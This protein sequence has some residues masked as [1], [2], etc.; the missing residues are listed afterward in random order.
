MKENKLSEILNRI[1][2][3]LFLFCF[4]T[5]FLSIIFTGYED[6]KH[7]Y[8]TNERLLI[9]FAAF[10]LLI[11]F[12]AVYILIQKYN[13]RPNLQSTPKFT[14]KQAVI[15]FFCAV[16]VLFLLQL[17]SGYLL[18]MKPVTDMRYIERYAGSFA[19]T[20]NY[21]LI[22]KDCA[23][24]S[25]YLIRYPNNFALVFL[26]SAIYRICYLIF[27]YVPSLVPVILNALAINI[28]VLLT[29][30]TARKLFG[31][32]KALFVLALCFLF[33]PFYTY[34]PYYYT[35]SLS[36]P[37]CIGAIYIFICA[38]KSD[39]KYKKYIMLAVC[40][41]VIFIGYKLKGS[42]LILLA[43]A[44]IYTVLKFS[45]K[46]TLCIALAL[47]AGFG[48]VSAAFTAGFNRSGIV[49]KEQSDRYEYP[50]THWV[51]MGLKGLGHYN[52]KDSNYTSSFETKKEK[53]EANIQE[54]K[55]RI[56]DFGPDGLYDHLI[57]KAVWTWE[58]G[59]YY[60]SHHISD[61]KRENALHSFVL[62]DGENYLS[63]F[64]YSN[65]FQLLLLFLILLSV[66]RGCIKP[67]IDIMTLFKGIIFAVLI[68]LLIWETRSRYL[69][70]FT[71]LFIVVAA[72][73]LDFLLNG[74]KSLLKNSK[75]KNRHLKA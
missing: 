60:I 72:D 23:K 70:N 28:T 25:V 20:G 71:P 24:G 43:A 2:H 45:I 49:T 8:S 27:G 65:G 75:Y 38:V 6:E 69:Y 66:I 48:C 64:V 14:D 47:I 52:L 73:G 29:V 4:G 36:A 57:N 41:T 5:V 59:T 67:K 22:Q 13:N 46:Q 34:V 37:F 58:D 54:I 63:F 1:F 32:R 74:I 62:S 19:A 15:F 16:G 21:D 18:Q 33:A 40:G 42:I 44:L 7:G 51:M 68:F 39:N 50:Y 10:V 12:S 56:K 35:D 30:F 53:Q 26:L 55:S 17:I 11:I 61:P 9:I 3:I 31:N